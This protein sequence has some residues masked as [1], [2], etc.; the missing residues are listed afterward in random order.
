MKPPFAPASEVRDAARSD[1]GSSSVADR[2]RRP[3]GLRVAMALYGDVTYDSRVLREAE[4]LCGA[5]HVVTI[6]SLS[7]VP[8]AEAP[9]RVRTHVP[10]RSSVLPDGSSPFLQS[11]RASRA[12]RLVGRLRWIV[13]YT[14]NIRAW[15]RWA[16]AAAGDVDVWHAHDLTGLLSVGPLVRAPCR[17]VYDSHE[18]FLETGT[19]ARLPRPVRRILSGY[20][21]FLARRASALVTVNE[22]YATV[23]RKRLRPRRILIVRNCPPRWMPSTTMPSPLRHAAGVRPSQRLILYHGMFAPHRGIEESAEALLAPVLG[24]AHLAL[25]GFGTMRLELE[26]LARDPRFQGR[27][28]VIDAVPPGELLEWVAGAE[29]D[30]MP[31]QRSSLN[32][33]LCTPNKLWESLAAG[34]PVVVS[35]FPVMRRIVLDDPAGPLGAVC[36][37]SDPSAIAAAVASLMELPTDER[38]AL[39]SRCLQAA[40]ERWNWEGE[41]ARLVDLY[42]ELLATADR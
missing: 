9:F 5:G 33:W 1:L 38:T 6:Y 19:A 23:L 34:V 13:G 3:T 36:D 17:L 32:H 21:G 2:G 16:V 29:V 30:V 40:H 11:R 25:L 37:P 35:D 10:N 15:G 7:G 22:G 39:R 42:A 26:Q 4:T 27:L 31:L 41:S 8:P 24:S 20:E 14:R 18:I 12:A 28:H